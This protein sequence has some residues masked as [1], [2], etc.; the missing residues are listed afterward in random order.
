[1]KQLTIVG[2]TVTIPKNLAVSLVLLMHELAT[3]AVKYGAL[4]NPMGRVEISWMESPN[5]KVRL[6][7]KEQFGPPVNQ[8]A[9]I[10][11][12]TKLLRSAFAQ[13]EDAYANNMY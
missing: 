2:S 5:Q 4:S 8:P 1:L 7:W 6:D 13:Q 11:F 12:G 10:G 3:N 9:R